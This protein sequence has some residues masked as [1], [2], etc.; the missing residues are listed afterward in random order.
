VQEEKGEEEGVVS[1]KK[2]GTQNQLG[3]GGKEGSAKKTF[4][5]VQEGYRIQRRRMYVHEG[6][7]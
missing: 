2:K 3:K 7:W 4:R 1:S 6:S 5:G